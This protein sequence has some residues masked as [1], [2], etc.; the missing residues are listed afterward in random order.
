[1]PKYFLLEHRQNEGAG[2]YDGGF[3]YD[4]EGAV[5]IYHVDEKVIFPGESLTPVNYPN[6]D[7]TL[8][9]VDLEEADGLDDLD[10]KANFGDFLG[11]PGSEQGDFFRQS[12]DDFY[13]DSDLADPVRLKQIIIFI[14]I[15]SGRNERRKYFLDAVTNR[16]IYAF[17]NVIANL[18]QSNNHDNIDALVAILIEKSFP[19]LN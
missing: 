7:P 1:M 14:Q 6:D 4:N 8:K 15:F 18:V 12:Q 19:Q 17:E 11:Y 10:N 5:L 3:N 13:K 9:G 2:T 16:G